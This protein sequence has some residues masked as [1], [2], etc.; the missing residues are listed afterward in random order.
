[1]QNMAKDLSFFS[2][3]WGILI[4]AF[5]AAFQGSLRHGGK[6]PARD[7]DRTC[8]SNIFLSQQPMRSWHSWWLIRTYLQSLG[9]VKGTLLVHKQ[10][11][12]ALFKQDNMDDM[13]S[14]ASN[15]VFLVMFPIFNLLLVRC[16]PVVMIIP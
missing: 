15:V 16:S 12:K 10:A 5:G 1:M 14:E 6:S 7:D 13:S 8:Q 9:E 2:V 4:L 3:V 11:L